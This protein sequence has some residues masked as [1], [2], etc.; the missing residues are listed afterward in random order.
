MHFFPRRWLD[1]ILT[2][3]L[4]QRKALSVRAGLDYYIEKGGDVL[5]QRNYLR[6]K[7]GHSIGR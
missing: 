1:K 4:S 6:L 7:I 3:S 5:G 2:H